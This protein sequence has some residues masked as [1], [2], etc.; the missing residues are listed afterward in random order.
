MFFNVSIIIF[1]IL[2]SLTFGNLVVVGNGSNFSGDFDFPDAFDFL[3]E[4]EAD[5]FNDLVE[6]DDLDLLGETFL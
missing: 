4:E 5:L 6:D 2:R 3:E 1:Y